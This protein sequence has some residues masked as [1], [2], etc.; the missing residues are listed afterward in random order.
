MEKIFITNNQE[1]F[2]KNKD[3][4]K[5]NSDFM[6]IDAFWGE[7]GICLSSK[8]VKTENY[9]YISDEECIFCNGT[10]FYDKSWGN[11]A[12][13]KTYYDFCEAFKKNTLSE[14]VKNI[15]RKQN[16][17]YL[18]GIKTHDHIYVFV[19]ENAT[20]ALYYTSTPKAFAVCDTY[21][22]IAAC[23]DYQF[24]KNAF[25]DKNIRGGAPSGNSTFFKDIFRLENDE[26][27]DI[28][29]NKNSMIINRCDLNVYDISFSN[30]D[31]AVDKLADKILE[32]SKLRLLIGDDPVAVFLTGGL[33]SRTELSILNKAGCKL[34]AIYWCGEDNITNGY[35]RDKRIGKK[36]SKK[37]GI[38]YEFKDVSVHF[39]ACIDS[40][41][42]DEL[43]KYGEYASFYAH[44][45]KLLNL[46]ENKRDCCCYANGYGPE[47]LN[48]LLELDNAVCD[49]PQ[50]DLDV[51]VKKVYCRSKTN[52]YLFDEEGI[53]CYLKKTLKELY[54]RYYNRNDDIFGVKE[55]NDLFNITRLKADMI[56][57][58]L[59]NKYNYAFSELCEKSITD[60]ISQIPYEWKKNAKLQLALIKKLCPDIYGIEYFT[61]AKRMKIC[62]EKGILVPIT[63]SSFSKRIKKN[64]L[65]NILKKK[66][67]KMRHINDYTFDSPILHLVRKQSIDYINESIIIKNR[68]LKL[69]KLEIENNRISNI[70]I[71]EFAT[72]LK[73]M[74]LYYGNKL[75][76]NSF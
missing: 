64:Q 41:S 13:K 65:Y 76:D 71:P 22:H 26:I 14:T 51:F 23:D 18:L 4:C 73:I 35:E 70:F 50:L 1:W 45:Q 19:D 49:G 34:D 55:C 42:Y 32:V 74:D 5:S 15:R 54:S 31:D 46:L 33:D 39:K 56:T 20:F 11:D 67:L 44:N 6:E 21:W 3:T 47:P 27:I 38:N 68:F 75:N 29:I 37:L 63:S 2:S 52:E 59:I 7:T 61:H 69:H 57:N 60:Y 30:F 8:S 72:E 58:N 28:D 48:S 10:Y 24:N 9:I 12:L 36:I 25:I 53:I 62:E 66:Y 17:Q 43:C 16:G 40:L